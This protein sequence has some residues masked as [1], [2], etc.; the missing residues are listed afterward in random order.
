MKLYSLHCLEL[1]TF[2]HIWTVIFGSV[3]LRVFLSE[4][5]VHLIGDGYKKIFR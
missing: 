3:V 4:L 2:T 5:N 1:E